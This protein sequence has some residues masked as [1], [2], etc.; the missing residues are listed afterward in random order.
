MSSS[1]QLVSIIIP[2]YNAEST[3]EKCLNSVLNQ[4]YKNFE[5]IIINDGSTDSTSKI[6]ED[7]KS[8]DERISAYYQ[9]NS[10]VSKARNFGI[11]KSKGDYI[12]FVDSDDW[13]ERNYC[14][15]LFNLI[16][17]NQAD[18][19]IV[20]VL[21]EDEVGNS[22]FFV[23][24]GDSEIVIYDKQKALELLLE[25]KSIKSYPCAKLYKKELFS[26][27][28]FPEHLEAFEDYY[29]LFKV[30]FSAKTVVKSNI[31][32]YHY[33]QYSNSLSHNLTPMRAYHFFLAIMET[34]KFLNISTTLGNKKKI[35]NNMI[36]KLLMVLKRILRNT[37]KEEMVA[38]KE[39]IR[40]SFQDF[41]KYPIREIGLEYYFYLRLYFYSPNLYSKIIVKK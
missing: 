6:I 25:D 41:F 7:F 12:C 30:F 32:L 15:T 10:G 13:V 1:Q 39:E 24:Y 9:S 19:S 17:E 37:S 36:K 14:S 21:Y 26:N 35:I 18:I 33:I 3:L 5:V 34:Y 23:E 28:S 38:E 29:T 2:C 8:K 20:D 31:P 16:I 11:S 40:K 4:D 27:I 22:T